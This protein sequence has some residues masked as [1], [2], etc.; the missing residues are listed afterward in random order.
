VSGEDVDD[1]SKNFWL[2]PIIGLFYGLVA[3]GLFYAL[4]RTFSGLVS[5]IL[6]IL[7]I[8]I[9]NRFLHFDGL[10]DLGD[11][12]VAT[13]T[14]EKK[15]AAMKDTRVGAGGVSYGILFSLLIIASL[16]SLPSYTFFIPVA[17]EVLAKNSLLT[18]A[19][20]GKERAGLGSP[21]V[22][23]TR[24]VSAVLSALLSFA[25][26]LPFA[27][28]PNALLMTGLGATVAGELLLILIGMLLAS[29]TTGWIM[30]KVAHHN[31][32]CVNGDVMGATNELSKAAVL[33]TAL[34]MLA[35]L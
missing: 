33:L 25:L 9:L 26:L 2:V 17:M 3:G 11:G 16:S 23:N 27:L 28:L 10:I 35:W 19:A 20:F 21:F 32:G 6:V 14:Q 12:L 34:A 15:L 31:F 29:T 13:G 30:S 7:V 8:H 1:L 4:T 22:K 24:P 5:A 18:V